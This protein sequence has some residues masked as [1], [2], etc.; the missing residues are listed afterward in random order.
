M[1]INSASADALSAPLIHP[2]QP[3]T[4]RNTSNNQQ[5]GKS[6]LHKRVSIKDVFANRKQNLTL[7]ELAQDDRYSVYYLIFRR[8]RWIILILGLWAPNYPGW[9]YW[10]LRNLYPALIYFFILYP[11]TTFLTQESYWSVPVF[12]FINLH[13]SG[14]FAY[15][16]ARKYWKQKPNHLINFITSTFI[17]FY[18][19]ISHFQRSYEQS[20]QNDELKY[21]K[22]Q[23]IGTENDKE[24]TT[25]QMG[26]Q[27]RYKKDNRKRKRMA[28]SKF[29]QYG[30]GIGLGALSLHSD[31]SL[32]QHSQN[33]NKN[34]NRK[35]KRKIIKSKEKIDNNN[36]NNEDVIEN[37]QLKM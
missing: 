16:S 34:K 37:K 1:S 11:W 21:K 2:L 5:F 3:I 29:H 17:P 8:I 22:K 20:Q 9:P 13:L 33:K 12:L 10:C 23:S 19:D 25:L 26:F 31:T 6:K 14:I 32:N 7:E 27:Q 28:K 24:A 36:N 35:R 15:R 4:L 30:I 18:D